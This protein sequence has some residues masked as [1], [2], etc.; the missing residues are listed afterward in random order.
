M[1]HP[2]KRAHLVSQP[3]SQLGQKI[4]NHWTGNFPA[5]AKALREGGILE[6]EARRVS[7]LAATVME[8]SLAKGNP[9]TVAYELAMEE[10]KYP[11]NHDR[12]PQPAA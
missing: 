10:W 8:Q 2:A 5:E 4:L 11:P 3:L 7:E 9:W 12:A 1:S 6:A